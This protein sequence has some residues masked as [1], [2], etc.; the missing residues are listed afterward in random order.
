MWVFRVSFRV[1]TEPEVVMSVAKCTKIVAQFCSHSEVRFSQR[2]PRAHRLREYNHAYTSAA[3]K[4][5]FRSAC[6]PVLWVRGLPLDTPREYFN[7]TLVLV[8][9]H[10]LLHSYSVLCVQGLL[11]GCRAWNCSLMCKL[12]RYGAAAILTSTWYKY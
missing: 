5:T 1:K 6:F 3:V 2:G 4:A 12:F 8:V 10:G 9:S 7:K 11:A